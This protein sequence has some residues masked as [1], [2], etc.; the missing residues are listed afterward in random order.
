LGIYFNNV[1]IIELLHIIYSKVKLKEKFIISS[2]NVYICNYAAKNS[3]FANL[4]NSFSF[5]NPDGIGVYLASK[6]LFGKK[7]LIE[8]PTGTTGTDLLFKL[9][10]EYC[11]LKYFLIG[12][13]ENC[14]ERIQENFSFSSNSNNIKIVGSIYKISDSFCD[15][16]IIN[17]SGADILMV[18]LGTPHQEE[19]IIKNKDEID[20]PVIIAVGSGL[21]FLAGIKKR[22]P[23]WMQKIGLEW[24]YRM[25]Q[26]PKRL[27]KRY[28]V[29]IPIFTYHVLIQKIKRGKNLIIS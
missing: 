15:F 25:F 5:V 23:L 12:G 29:G 18:A 10:K 17:K 19:W 13:V 2:P 22:A 8:R 1:S 11:D 20:V 7:G 21:D 4:I 16:N 3:Y 9:F 14:M 6:F 28:L 24:L 27:W 26:E